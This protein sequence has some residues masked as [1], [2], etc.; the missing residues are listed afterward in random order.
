MDQLI[1]TAIK[2]L[3]T[4]ANIAN[5][6]TP[7]RLRELF[8]DFGSRHTGNLEWLHMK[9]FKATA[10]KTQLRFRR[11]FK[12]KV[13]KCQSELLPYF[14]FFLLYCIFQL[15]RGSKTL[16]DRQKICSKLFFAQIAIFCLNS[17][18]DISGSSFIS[19]S[20]VM[21]FIFASFN[22]YASFVCASAYFSLERQIN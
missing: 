8:L 4:K 18:L 14:C 10:Q 15:K 22:I 7:C 2:M 3:Q 5:E 20:L 17:A 9:C 6:C 13:Q 16:C 12:K 1:I 21:F 19:I 11:R